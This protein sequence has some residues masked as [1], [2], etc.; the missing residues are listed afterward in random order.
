MLVLSQFWIKDIARP[1]ISHTRFCCPVKM[2]GGGEPSTCRIARGSSAI[3]LEAANQ[4]VPKARLPRCFVV[5]QF[6]HP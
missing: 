4:K 3:D 5:I 6:P 1:P 2:G